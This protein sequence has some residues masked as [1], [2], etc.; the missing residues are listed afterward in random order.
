MDTLRYCGFVASC[1]ILPVVH[2]C[3]LYLDMSVERGLL[4]Q[5]RPAH[6]SVLSALSFAWHAAT[7]LTTASIQPRSI[8]RTSSRHV[9]G[10]GAFSRASWVWVPHVTSVV[11]NVICCLCVVWCGLLGLLGANLSWVL[12]VLQ[13]VCKWCHLLVLVGAHLWVS[14]VNT[15]LHPSPCPFTLLLCG[16]D[17]LGPG[18]VLHGRLCL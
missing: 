16:A 8:S 15:L 4:R 7:C 5:Q 14:A 6:V 17:R 2:M 9:R 12:L 13:A 1:R 11:I 3:C 18:R 10:P